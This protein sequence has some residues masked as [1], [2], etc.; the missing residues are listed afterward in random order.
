MV[1]E[2]SVL[3]N[4]DP[5]CV[6]GTLFAAIRVTVDTS[7]DDEGKVGA[8]AP[9]VAADSAAGENIDPVGKSKTQGK[10]TEEQVKD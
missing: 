9:A 8:L 10:Y 1:L 2:G 6:L 7:D 3:V 4:H 5:C